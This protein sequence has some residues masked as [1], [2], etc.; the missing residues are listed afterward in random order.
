MYKYSLEKANTYPE[1][2]QDSQCFTRHAARREQC[3]SIVPKAA[4]DCR[5]ALDAN[6]L[7][8]VVIAGTV[9]QAYD[10]S[11]RLWPAVARWTYQARCR[12]EDPLGVAIPEM[13]LAAGNTQRSLVDYRR[14]M[15]DFLLPPK[16]ALEPQH[17]VRFDQPTSVE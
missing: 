7:T 1:P 13:W 2:I 6:S 15:I 8:R 17:R 14:V 9:L 11:N 12:C 3:S 16:N 10:I 4:L 5:R